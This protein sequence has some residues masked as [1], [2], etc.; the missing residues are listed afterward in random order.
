VSDGS[1]LYYL[2]I[3]GK[4]VGPFPLDH[5]EK[6]M[7]N[8]DINGSDLVWTEGASEWIA[9]EAALRT[10]R[11]ARV[12]A[13]KSPAPP[14]PGFREPI[15]LRNAI[16]AMIACGSSS[17]FLILAFS[18]I[19]DS[20]SV[21]LTFFVAAAYLAWW[22]GIEFSGVHL[23][24]GRLVMPARLPFW[25]FIL[26]IGRR[27]VPLS[28]IVI[29]EVFSASPNIHGVAMVIGQRKQ[30]LFFDSVFVRDSFVDAL[31]ASGVQG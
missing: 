6:M 11:A 17:C 4:T 18:L 13:G 15:I 27:N 12:S 2:A 3:Q 28:A 29:A 9:L 10:M 25:P 31:R 20:P 14:R 19:S 7:R 1:K 24:A 30:A 16:Y 23:S 26:P 21:S 22:T 8:G 5:I